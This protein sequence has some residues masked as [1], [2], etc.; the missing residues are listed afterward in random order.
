MYASVVGKRFH[1]EHCWVILKKE[2]KWQFERA[3]LHQKSNKKQKNYGNASPATSTPSTADSVF[4]GE[5]SDT[6]VYQNRPIGQ[7]AAKEQLRRRQGKEKD[8]ET[9]VSTRLQQM[10]E[11]FVDI[12]EKKDKD[13]KIMLEQNALLLKQKQEKQE[14]EIMKMDTSTLN[15]MAAAYFEEK[16]MEILA[17][18]RSS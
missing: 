12:E 15:P 2:P 13:R 9:S 17:K 6:F 7:K 10:N 18:R 5:D 11:T 8:G 1:L 4:L 16:M 14:M 3:S